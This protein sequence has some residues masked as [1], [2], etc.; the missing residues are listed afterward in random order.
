MAITYAASG[1]WTK[2]SETVTVVDADGSHESSAFPTSG[3]E[4]AQAE[5]ETGLV[6]KWQYTAAD[7]PITIGGVGA[8]PNGR[9]LPS[10]SWTDLE[11]PA[12]ASG[13]LEK[14]YIPANANYIRC[15]YTVTASTY[16]GD[17]GHVV[18]VYTNARK[19]D[20]GFSISGLGADPS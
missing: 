8:D 14:V 17:L 18:D 10:Q 11:L 20:I 12:A 19:S 4:T 7:S 16:G 2:M 1:E 9:T 13:S 15:H 3:V 6:A 5:E